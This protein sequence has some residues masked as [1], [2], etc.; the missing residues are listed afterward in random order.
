MDLQKEAAILAY[1]I[2]TAQ[3]KGREEG[4]K[5]GEKKGKIEVAKAMLA[6]GMEVN[7]IAKITGLSIKEVEKLT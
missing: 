7:T 3:E 1:K 6:E 5:I 2:E 4:I